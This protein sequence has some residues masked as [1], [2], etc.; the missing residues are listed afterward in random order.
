MRNRFK[1]RVCKVLVEFD[2]HVI[3]VSREAIG[4]MRSS[5]AEIGGLRPMTSGANSESKAETLFV[6]PEKVRARRVWSVLLITHHEV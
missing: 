5:N 2:D 6:I 1:D 3:P 4:I